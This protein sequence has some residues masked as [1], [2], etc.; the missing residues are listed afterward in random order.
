MLIHGQMTRTTPELAY[1]SSSFCTTP[2][3]GRRA[4]DVRFNEH[5]YH[6]HGESSV[7]AGFEPETLWPEAD[8]L[9]LGS[10][11]RSLVTLF[12]LSSGVITKD[13]M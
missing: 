6:I 12:F 11:A 9:P 4:H 5:Q 10:A 13:L 2:T 8:I 1:S 3:A 7:E